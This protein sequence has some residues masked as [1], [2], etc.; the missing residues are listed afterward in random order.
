MTSSFTP[1]FFGGR[2]EPLYGV[3]HKPDPAVDRS[4]GVLFLPP[5]GQDYKRCHKP[6]QKLARDLAQAGF[7]VLR[8]DYAGSGDSADLAAWSLDSWREDG[9]DALSQLQSM[10]GARDLSAFGIRLGASVAVQL[11]VPLANLILW[12]PIGDGPAYLEEIE[13]LNRDLLYKFRHSFR[14]GRH[15]VVPP[16]QM[17]GHVFP[18]SMRDS[19][20]DY[21]LEAP[22]ANRA[23]RALWIDAEATPATAGYEHF[24]DQLAG[25][26]RYCQVEVGCHWR[27]LAEISNVIMGQPV[28]RQVLLHLK[29]ESGGHGNSA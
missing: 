6:L 23:R 11:D 19:L 5:L 2:N 27:S 13:K 22:G 21:A 4:H 8:F 20:R 3:H 10:S 28:A 1:L 14:S 25:A 29:E 18:D 16:G 26:E 15:V 7:H 12:D 24:Q 17:V 9:I